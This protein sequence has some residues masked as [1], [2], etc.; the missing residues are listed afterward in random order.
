MTQDEKIELLSMSVGRAR[1]E[2]IRLEREL[3]LLKHD[4]EKP[5]W[6][7]KLTEDNIDEWIFFDKKNIATTIKP[8]CIAGDYVW[9]RKDFSSIRMSGYPPT[10]QGIKNELN[11]G[12]W[13]VTRKPRPPITADKK[14]TCNGWF[15]LL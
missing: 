5:W 6:W 9:R 3:E 2:I 12:D 8:S 4:F 14:I 1:L 10:F 15:D 13:T 7:N 11:S